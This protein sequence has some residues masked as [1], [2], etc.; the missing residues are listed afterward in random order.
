MGLA[1]LERRLERLVEGAFAKA[2][3]SGVQPVE[4]LR[5]LTRE[6][7]TSRTHGVRGVIAPNHFTVALAPA[8]YERFSSFLDSL[9]RDLGD[10]AREHART[11]GYAF[12]GPVTVELTQDPG[13][14]T[15]TFLLAS[16][17]REGPGGR[18]TGT[19]VLP[20]G[21]RVSVGEDPVTI[22]RMPE[23]EVVLN[24]QNVS[25]RH[26]EVRRQGGE[27]VVVDLGSTN[28][29]KV[30]GSGVKE[31]RLDDGDEITVGASTLRF[32]TS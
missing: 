32:E 17:M 29:T 4:L 18:G 25:R 2:F 14:S 5:R 21:K 12:V 22:G 3:R 9:V 15:G 30:N 1:D 10:G 19:V 31:R 28:G 20:D 24:D 11:E 7:D 13:V 16:E 27:F 26:A 6:M 23:C 8:D